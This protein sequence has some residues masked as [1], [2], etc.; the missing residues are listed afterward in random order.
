[1]APASYQIRTLEIT[2]LVQRI[3]FTRLR[4]LTQIAGVNDEIRLVRHGVYLVN[5][6]LQGD[7]NVLIGWLIKADVAIADLHKGKVRAF[8]SVL[9]AVFVSILGES[10]GYRDAAAHSPNQASACPG[11]ALQETATINAVVVEVL[12]ILIDKILFFVWHVP[13]V[14]FDVLS[15]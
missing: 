8:V 13:S 6:L 4:Q 15:Y 14:I 11:H 10:P 12:Q 9:V 2:E 3:E 5:C 7:R 1:M